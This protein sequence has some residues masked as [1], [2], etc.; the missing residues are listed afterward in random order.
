S[1]NGSA[2]V[3]NGV[4][5]NL[6]TVRVGT[7]GGTAAL[8]LTAGGSVTQDPGTT[9]TVAGT[10][11]L[12]ATNATLDN[13][14]NSFGAAVSA[15]GGNVTLRTAGALTLAA[16]VVTG[17]LVVRAGGGIS[18]VGAISGPPTSSLFD[19]GTAPITL[20]N[21]GNQLTGPTSASSVGT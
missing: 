19:A 20:T 6:G 5:L 2:G 9:L 16:S 1:G 12:S 14:G 13:N 8:N 7:P 15:N 18:Q 11:F 4:S 3:T 21:A 17:N 10:T